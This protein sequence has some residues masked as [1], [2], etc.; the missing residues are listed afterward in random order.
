[1]NLP[2]SSAQLTYRPL[3]RLDAFWF[4]GLL[5]AALVLYTLAL[6]NLPLRDWDEAT[7]AQVARELFERWRNWPE[8]GWS[9]LYPSLEGQPYLN[10]PPLVHWLIALSYTMF[11]VNEHAAR[12]PG[13]LLSALS[14]PLLY[15][16][17]REAMGRRIPALLA[18]LVYLTLLPVT[19]HGRLA[20]LD[21]PILCFWLGMLWLALRSRRDLRACLG[22]GLSLSLVCLTKGILGL[23]LLAIVLVFLSWDTPRLWRSGYLWGGLLLG[24]LPVVAWYAAQW[25]HS[26]DLVLKT[27]IL[28]QSLERVWSDVEGNGGPPWYYLLELLKYGWPWLAFLP[29]GLATTWEDRNRGWGKLVLVWGGIYLGAISLM[30]TKLPW[31]GLPLYPALALVVGVEL[32]AL[33]QGQRRFSKGATLLL[34]LG[35]TLSACFCFYELS[36]LLGWRPD[37]GGASQALMLILCALTLTLG[38]GAVLMWQQDRQA[39]PVLLWGMFVS[40]LLLFGSNLW[41]WELNEAYPVR[42]VAAILRQYLPT[43]STA[44]TSYPHYRPSLY[45]YSQHHVEPRS[46]AEL[47]QIWQKEAHAYLLLDQS[48]LDT[49]PLPDAIPLGS[50]VGWTLVERLPEGIPPGSEGLRL[51]ESPS[52]QRPEPAG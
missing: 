50:A 10:K 27:S 16:V 23:L 20:M 8:S 49:L 12:L 33:W 51:T 29:S 14:V 39:I 4:G 7:H 38:V 35:G 25:Q 24:S 11:G 34:S 41:L 28:H 13:A 2:L 3:R 19:R 44:Y 18:A 36:G 9:W 5:L 45:F 43:A 32:T 21:G 6:G 47:R 31:Y 15:L 26:G 46:S 48:A 17:G 37:S 22:L 1:M 42:P 30:L 52:P 40:L